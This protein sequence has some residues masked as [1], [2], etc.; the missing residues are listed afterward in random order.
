MYINKEVIIALEYVHIVGVG[1]L[2]IIL[3]IG[4]LTMDFS[5]LGPG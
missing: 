1:Q 5:L 4:L 3:S 2:Y